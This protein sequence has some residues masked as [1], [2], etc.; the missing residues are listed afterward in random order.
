MQTTGQQNLPQ[1]GRT[2]FLSYSTQHAHT[3]GIILPISTGLPS[4]PLHVQ[5]DNS[6]KTFGNQ[7]PISQRYNKCHSHLSPTKHKTNDST[8]YQKHIDQTTQFMREKAQFMREKA[9]RSNNSIHEGDKPVYEEE[10][11]SQGKTSKA[12]M[13]EP[14]RE[15]EPP[16][17][18]EGAI[19]NYKET[20]NNTYNGSHS[21]R[22]SAF[23]KQTHRTHPSM[24]TTTSKE[25]HR[26][27]NSNANFHLK[28]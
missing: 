22:T 7:Q 16:R 28:K 25:T 8:N 6:S 21:Q 23:S 18:H 2:I 12:L 14:N 26:R 4:S 1:M 20:T 5:Y 13:R 9:C 19:L 3:I 10:N 17:T 24:N 15:Q 11:N 27:T